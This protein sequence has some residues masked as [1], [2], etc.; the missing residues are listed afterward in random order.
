VPWL[1]RAVEDVVDGVRKPADASMSGLCSGPGV[2]TT[3]DKGVITMADAR[4]QPQG[5][6]ARG[7]QVTTEAVQRAVNIIKADNKVSREERRAARKAAR[8]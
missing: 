8:A 4:W 3:D 2:A 1:W 7:E 6:P 5:P